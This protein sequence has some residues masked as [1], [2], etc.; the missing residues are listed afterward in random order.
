MALIRRQKRRP[1]KENDYI[2]SILGLFSNEVQHHPPIFVYA[3][4]ATGN[5][6]A[7]FMDE[8]QNLGVKGHSIS[9]VPSW[10]PR[11]FAQMSYQEAPP[12]AHVRVRWPDPQRPHVENAGTI[13][14][15]TSYYRING[16]RRSNATNVANS[17]SQQNHPGDGDGKVHGFT[18]A[19]GGDR[20]PLE[21]EQ[22]D[23]ILEIQVL[24]SMTVDLYFKSRLTRGEM[25]AW[26]LL[27]KAIDAGK[28]VMACVKTSKHIHHW[29]NLVANVEAG[30]TWKIV[31]H[32]KTGHIHEGINWNG[33]NAPLSF[34][35]HIN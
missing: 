27:K 33:E 30:T 9:N 15:K 25:A 8:D 11:I 29:L 12:G 20:T 35:F 23:I 10:L 2:F 17:T 7:L 21:I 1:R 24:P 5:I 16:L 28:A 18:I 22:D 3:R 14:A 6:M 26:R 13:A 34:Q 31:G 19:S 32:L 4:V